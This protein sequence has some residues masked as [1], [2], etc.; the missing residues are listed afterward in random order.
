MLT[1][2]SPHSIEPQC[3]F[4]LSYCCQRGCSQLSFIVG[5]QHW[6][7]CRFYM[8]FLMQINHN[9]NNNNNWVNKTKLNKRFL[10]VLCNHQY[11]R[12]KAVAANA[13]AA[14]ATYCGWGGSQY[15]EAS[16]AVW[17][18]PAPHL[19]ASCRSSSSSA[20]PATQTTSATL[21]S[22]PTKHSGLAKLRFFW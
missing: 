21:P 22:S 19:S 20:L 15:R 10:W 18:Q 13:A 7:V 8:H 12:G 14:A 5:R 1:H 11:S 16:A 4:Y 3:C 17:S 2:L 9:N 6:Y